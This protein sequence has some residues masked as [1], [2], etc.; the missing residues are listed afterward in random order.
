MF[1]GADRGIYDLGDSNLGVF[2]V[3][4]RL[5]VLRRTANGSGW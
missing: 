1:S 3:D 2:H 5:A 4:Y